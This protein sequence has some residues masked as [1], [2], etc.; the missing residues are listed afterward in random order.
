MP[1]VPLPAVGGAPPVGAATRGGVPGAE[2]GRIVEPWDAAAGG[3]GAAAA[4]GDA[5]LGT[6]EVAPTAGMVGA[7]GAWAAGVG[8]G[9]VATPTGTRGA[10]WGGWP[11]PEGGSAGGAAVGCVE[12]GAIFTGAAGAVAVGAF[13]AGG[14]GTA[15]AGGITTDTTGTGCGI[16][17]SGALG[18]TTGTAVV[19]TGTG[20]G[21]T[22]SCNC[23]P[24]AGCAVIRTGVPA[25][26]GTLSRTAS[27]SRPIR[28]CVT[29]CALVPA[30]SASTAC[31]GRMP[32]MS[33]AARNSA[34][35]ARGCGVGVGR[36]VVSGA[37]IRPIC[38][39]R[40][41]ED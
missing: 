13:A 30:T 14:A 16:A 19:A 4:V 15:V 41:N 23:P 24:G 17:G 36:S 21:C 1:D 35:A 12:A 27:I 7:V 5:G 18:A 39:S 26:I 37:V 25:G 8:I 22:E 9:V 34:D 32:S 28:S 10:D 11:R 6:G 40:V 33:S 3:M 38:R 31:P 2:R 29:P 20:S